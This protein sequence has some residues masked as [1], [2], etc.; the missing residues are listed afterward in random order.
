[1]SLL[2]DNLLVVQDSDNSFSVNRPDL[3]DEK[4]FKF[5]TPV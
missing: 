1:M 4:S 3:S 2:G 5:V